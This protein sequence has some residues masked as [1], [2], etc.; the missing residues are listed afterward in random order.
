MSKISVIVPFNNG[1]K[2]L[3]RCLKNLS[4]IEYDD[5][6]IILIDDF[7]KDNSEQIAKKYNNI[8]YFYTKEETTGVGN[9]RNL[10]IEKAINT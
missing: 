8:K 3:E 1:K 6:E 4:K 5:Y 2:Y 7:S 10:G 9:A